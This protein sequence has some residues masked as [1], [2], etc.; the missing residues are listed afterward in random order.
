MPNFKRAL[1]MPKP[2]IHQEY[3]DLATFPIIRVSDK[4]K[5][6]SLGDM[7]ANALAFI[8]KLIATG[9]CQ[10]SIESYAKLVNIQN[11]LEQNTRI[12]IDNKD[13]DGFR[14]KE[15]EAKLQEFRDIIKT[16]FVIPG[17]LLL[18]GDLLADRG[19]SDL[20]ILDILKKLVE[21][22]CDIKI[23]ISNHDIEALRSYTYSELTTPT[24]NRTS[25]AFKGKDGANRGF[26]QSMQ[27][28]LA[29]CSGDEAR[30]KEVLNL[31]GDFYIPNLIAV[32]VK[33][34]MPA[35][36]DITGKNLEIY[37]HAPTSLFNLHALAKQFLAVDEAKYGGILSKMITSPDDFE[38]AM[39]AVNAVFSAELLNY[40][41]ECCKPDVSEEDSRNILK[42]FLELL[43]SHD[44][45]EVYKSGDVS[46][47]DITAL[48]AI[49][50]ARVGIDPRR[51][52]QL[53]SLIEKSVKK[54][55][56]LEENTD[57]YNSMISMEFTYNPV[58]ILSLESYNYPLLRPIYIHGHDIN[59]HTSSIDSI[60]GAFSDIH[61]LPNNQGPLIFSIRGEVTPPASPTTQRHSRVEELDDES[62]D[63]E[64]SKANTYSP[65]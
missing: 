46:K 44:E 7:H 34:L 43:F 56:L 52:E 37:T 15:Y 1:A 62:D 6:V 22:K 24:Y 53:Q 8:H 2:S 38:K 20:L 50:I 45:D 27:S 30:V 42:K 26:V 54:Y 13:D 47:F 49:A 31:M 57:S 3:T 14:K 51:P 23:T 17:K 61:R 48:S 21:S 19:P 10:L 11:Y 16:I 60:L 63:N 32:Y 36:N 40:H 41:L 55:E 35:T 33:K 28:L 58:A 65:K 18:I 64:E 29:Y 59:T 5:R 9:Y 12:Y 4:S 25:F 39:E